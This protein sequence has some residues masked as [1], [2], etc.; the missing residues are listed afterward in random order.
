MVYEECCNPTLKECED[1]P[2]WELG[3]PPGIPK[4]QSAIARIETPC[5]GVFF[6]SLESYRNVDVENGLAWVIWTSLAQTM[7][8]R[9]VG[10]QTSNLTFDH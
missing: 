8:K 6:I 1:D 10:N 3:I 2:K 7:A 5:I 9:K 4:L